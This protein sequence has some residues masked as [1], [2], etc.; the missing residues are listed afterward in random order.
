VPANLTVAAIA[1]RNGV[2]FRFVTYVVDGMPMMVVSIAVA[3][4]HV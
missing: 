4:L 1:E 2:P 3:R